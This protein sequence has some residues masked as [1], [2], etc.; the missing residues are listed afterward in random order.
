VLKHWV[1]DQA[2]YFA[3]S[4]H[5]D[6]ERLHR[7]ERRIEIIFGT[8]LALAVVQ[9]FL[10]EQSNYVLIGVG[11]LPVLAAVMH[12]YIQK[13][14]L[15]EHTKQYDRMSVFYH[16]A[17]VHLELLINEGRTRDAQR[18]IAELGREALAENGDWIL[19]HRERPL[20]VPKG[21]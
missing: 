2:R 12:T 15:S 7:T 11:I 13:N 1:E 17:K 21:A 14:A 4:A 5:R 18:F 16:R 3:R 20:E 6:H 9:L 8:A 19:T 10:A